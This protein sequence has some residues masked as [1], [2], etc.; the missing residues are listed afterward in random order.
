LKSPVN[1]DNEYNIASLNPKRAKG[2]CKLKIKEGKEIIFSTAL[3]L[4]K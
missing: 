4:N 2:R 1:L 3:K